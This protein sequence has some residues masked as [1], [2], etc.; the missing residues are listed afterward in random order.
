MSIVKPGISCQRLLKPNYGLFDMVQQQVT[1]AQQK[2]AYRRARVMR[3][4]AYT[5]LD[6]RNRCFRLPK[7]RQR[8]PQLTDYDGMIRS[9]R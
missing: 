6:E 8:Q 5:P 1:P 9:E 2:V 3:G 7:I 4:Q